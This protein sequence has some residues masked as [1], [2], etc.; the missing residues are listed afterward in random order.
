MENLGSPARAHLVHQF[1]GQQIARN[2]LDQLDKDEQI[3]VH[4]ANV[5]DDDPT[6]LAPDVTVFD[7]NTQAPLICVEVCRKGML[8]HEKKKLEKLFDYGIQE[9][10]IFVYKGSIKDY[11]I[12]EL[13]K[14]LQ[15]GEDEENPTFSDV[16][17]I[18]IDEDL[19]I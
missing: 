11:E 7:I 3:A 18:D 4:E 5:T 2:I 17:A 19:S 10:F 6:S 13:H 8:E 1:I 14:Y 15:T 12:I 9:V 16:L